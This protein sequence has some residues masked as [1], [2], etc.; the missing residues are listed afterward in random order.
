MTIHAPSGAN[1]HGWK[2]MNPRDDFSDFASGSKV[3]ISAWGNHAPTEQR[4]WDMKKQT[5]LDR[6]WE[7]IIEREK[8]ALLASLE[9]KEKRL[10]NALADYTRTYRQLLDYLLQTDNHQ[11]TGE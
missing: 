4:I 6:Q 2:K 7:C 10:R 3:F 1:V 11:T 5:L 8:I 9:S